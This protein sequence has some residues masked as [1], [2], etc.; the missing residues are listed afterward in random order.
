M[1]PLDGEE[2]LASSERV[3][4]SIG[5]RPWEFLAVTP[6]ELNLM[7]EAALGRER[8]R[9]KELW[10]RF[11][12]LAAEVVNISGKS[13]RRPV[14]AKDYVRFDDD[15]A[16]LPPSPA[17]REARRLQAMETARLHKAKF[18]T[19]L[20]DESVQGVTGGGNG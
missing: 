9:E 1:E 2:F 11:A 13:V 14:K 16:N 7:A 15:K 17:E 18:W 12:F 3:A 10:R 6:G 19:L 20:R 4:Y 8:E 5:L